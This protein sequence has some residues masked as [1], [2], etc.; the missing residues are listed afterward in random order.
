M[1]RGHSTPGHVYDFSRDNIRFKKVKV[2]VGKTQRFFEETHIKQLKA[3]PIM[4]QQKLD[5]EV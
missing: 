2:S 4:Y 3:L 5:K 1:F